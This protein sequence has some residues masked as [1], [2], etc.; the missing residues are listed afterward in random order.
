MN[1]KKT[2]QINNLKIKWSTLYEK[3][4][5][6]T[7]GTKKDRIVLEEFRTKKDAIG[8]AEDTTDYLR[9]KV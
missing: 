4:Q 7:L 5:V 8:F 1:D 6:S 9:R 2:I 3:W